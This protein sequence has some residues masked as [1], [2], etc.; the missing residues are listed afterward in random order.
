[1]EGISVIGIDL[2]K[3]VFQL[4]ATTGSGAIAWEKRLRRAAFIK[5]LEDE[6]LRCLVGMEA[7]GS[8]H[9]WARWLVAREFTVKLMAPKAVRAYRAGCTRVIGAMPGRWPRRR[10]AAKWPRCG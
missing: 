1:M 5:F 10:A 9:H 8:A 3:R 7:C 4:C 2:A 6:A